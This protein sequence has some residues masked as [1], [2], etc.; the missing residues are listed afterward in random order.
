MLKRR[1]CGLSSSAKA[2]KQ[3]DWRDDEDLVLKGDTETRQVGRRAERDLQVSV[4]SGDELDAALDAALGEDHQPAVSSRKDDNSQTKG[5]PNCNPIVWMDLSI[6]GKLRGRVHFELF[7]D[8]VPQTAENFRLLCLGAHLPCGRQVGYKGTELHKVVPGRIVEG[9]EF[10]TSAT[11]KDFEDEG[12]QLTHSRAGLLS[13]RGAGPD[14][15]SS[16]FQITLK[17]LPEFDVK[18]VVFG[19]VLPTCFQDGQVD[20][21]GALHVLH[22]VEAMGTGA[23]SGTPMEAIAIEDCGQVPPDL[24]WKLINWD[25]HD[26]VGLLHLQEEAVRYSRGGWLPAKLTDAVKRDNLAAVLE[27]TA[28]ALEGWEWEAKKAERAGDS[29]RAREIEFNSR[30][31]GKVLEEAKYKAGTVQGDAEGAHGRNAQSQQLQLR[32]LQD[33]MRKLY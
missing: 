16:R 33:S 6:N 31:I 13:M 4:D 8:I 26:A 17:P 12:F 10:D 29:E 3:R 15:N 27:L 20:T 28:V 19:Q 23:R 32:D 5:S 2:V 1:I 25:H 30:S 9:G 7:H 18:Q 21:S 24:A 11:G 22:W 14:A